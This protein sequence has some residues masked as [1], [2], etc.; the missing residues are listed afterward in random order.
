MIPERWPEG[1]GH[2]KE[3]SMGVIPYE[4]TPVPQSLHLFPYAPVLQFCKLPIVVVASYT[5]YI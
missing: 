3:A 1:G 2:H 5:M 4:D